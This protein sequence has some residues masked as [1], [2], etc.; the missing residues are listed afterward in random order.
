MYHYA[1][2]PG[3]STQRSREVIAEFFDLST[4]GIPGNDGTPTSHLLLEHFTDDL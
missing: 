4:T 2:R 3:L 1:D